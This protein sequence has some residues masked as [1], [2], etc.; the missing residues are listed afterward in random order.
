MEYTPEERMRRIL[1]LIDEDPECQA[2]AESME[3]DRLVH[4][5]LAG[6]LPM[7]EG[8]ELWAYPTTLHLFHGRVMEL[9][10]RRLRF[11][12]ELADTQ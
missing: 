9:L 7:E 12:G 8:R 6:R 1:K 10:S 2:A 11:P 3:V 5:M 4:E